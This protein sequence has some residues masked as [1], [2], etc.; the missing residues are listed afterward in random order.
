MSTNP[1]RDERLLQAMKEAAEKAPKRRLSVS[2]CDEIATKIE[3]SADDCDNT[4]AH[5]FD[6]FCLVFENKEGE[7]VPA[8][9]VL[10]LLRGTHPTLTLESTFAYLQL[11]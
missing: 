3:V 8:E 11:R 4:I 10:R 7:A 5:C 6:V 2:Q 9:E 1:F